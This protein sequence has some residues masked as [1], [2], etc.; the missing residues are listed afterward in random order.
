MSHKHF[1]L[2]SQGKETSEIKVAQ[3]CNNWESKTDTKYCA[4]MMMCVIKQLKSK[5]GTQEVGT[6]M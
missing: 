3:H 1:I 6:Q 2:Y 5:L 4:C